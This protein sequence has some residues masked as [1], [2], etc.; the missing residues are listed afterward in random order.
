VLNKFAIVPEHFILAT[1]A[2]APQTHLLE[3][4]DLEATWACLQAYDSTTFGAVASEGGDGRK[5]SG[6]LYAFFN[7]SPL[8]G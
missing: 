4:E 2:F 3:K 5:Q 6:G 8:S 7:F 1:T